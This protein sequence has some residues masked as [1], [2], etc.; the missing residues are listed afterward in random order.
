MTPH[1]LASRAAI[2]TMAAGGS[3]VDA[4]IAA[5]AM[6][7]VVLPDTC[8]PGGDLFALIHLPGDDKPFALNA[9]GRAGSGADAAALRTGGHAEFPARHP[10]S[11]TVPG[12]V[13]GWE[14]LQARFGRLQLAQSL[15]PAIEAARNGFPASHELS[16]SLRRIHALIGAEPSAAPLY[17]DGRP[18]EPGESLVRVRHGDTLEQIAEGGR[19]AFFGGDVGAGICAASHGAV[20]PD[21]LAR[22]QAEW[23]DPMG[24][25]C[26]GLQAWTTPPNTQGYLT[27]AAAKIFE[28]LEPPRD[29]DDPR[30]THVAVEAYRAVA[31]E[32]NRVLSDPATASVP[33]DQLLDVETLHG[34]AQ[35]IRSDR[36]AAWPPPPWSPG[37]TAFLCARDREGMAVSFIQ[38]NYSGIGSGRSAGDTGIFLQNRGAGFNLEPG[39][40]NELQPGRRPLHT[41]SPTLW[42]AN[43]QLALLLGTRGGQYQ[44]QILLQLAAHHLWS[45]ATMRQ[46]QAR[47]RWLVDGWEQGGATHRVTLERGFSQRAID[48]LALRG[49]SVAETDPWQAGW[50]PVSMIQQDGRLVEGSADPR[51]TT[52]AA[53]AGAPT[54]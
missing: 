49:H 3:A 24:I 28:H 19:T 31:W 46:A 1:T 14:A 11:I 39:H 40:P 47:P 27:L 54:T 53:L 48:G 8:G 18:P 15:A 5:N 2:E 38:S 6:L 30:V 20:T 10:M 26:F 37:G 25:M 51:V 9:S 4:M 32:R 42:T 33:A 34:R 44:P 17:P 21:D 41:L 7:G 13:D 36:A 16:Q 43:G 23:V 52:S 12:C 22:V 29:P 35:K 45:G 50:G